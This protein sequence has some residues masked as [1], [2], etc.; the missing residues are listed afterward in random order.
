MADQ[1]D[2]A[3]L[4]ER[5]H[6]SYAALLEILQPLSE[7]QISRPAPSGWAIKDHLAHLA[8]WEL[9]IA[10][11]LQHHPRYAAMQVEEAMEQDKSTDE[12]NDLIYQQNAGLSPAEAREKFEA[13]HGQMLQVL[14]SLSDD[15]LFRPYADYLPE[16][17]Q[18]FQDPVLNWIV[19]NTYEHF[20]EHKAYIRDHVLSDSEAR[21]QVSE[22]GSDHSKAA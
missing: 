4:L 17:G 1:I 12:L 6:S 14:E 7:S 10:A 19:G 13:A 2:K 11:L 8:A 22:P 5:I 18:G 9:G 15:D 3:E 21:G 20:D 16:G